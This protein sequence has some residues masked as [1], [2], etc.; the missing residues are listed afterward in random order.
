[1]VT[2]EDSL[3]TMVGQDRIS[4]EEEAGLNNNNNNLVSLDIN[5]NHQH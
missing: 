5:N 1:M 4:G 2:R 3:R